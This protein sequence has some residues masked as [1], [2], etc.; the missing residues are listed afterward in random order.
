MPLTH[1]KGSCSVLKET[2][3]ELGPVV[4]GLGNRRKY[5]ESSHSDE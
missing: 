3:T 2:C 1:L 5:S 4:W